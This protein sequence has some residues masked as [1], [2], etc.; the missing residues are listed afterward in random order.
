MLSEGLLKKNSDLYL[1]H[2]M[3]L[4]DERQKRM[5]LGASF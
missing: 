3:M 5:D 2:E 1:K 4:D